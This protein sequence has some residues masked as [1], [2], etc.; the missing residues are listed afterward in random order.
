MYY[1]LITFASF[2]FALQF[3]FNNGY[4]K[5]NGSGWNSSLK[6]SFYTSAAGFF[7]VLII[8]NFQ[9]QIS[10]FSISVAIVYGIVNIAASY[11]AVKAFESANLSVYSVFSMIG[12]MLLPFLYGLI[13]G[14]PFKISRLICCIL[15]C[16]AV[17]F[18]VDKE[19]QN[20]NAFKYYIAVFVLN[21][22][23]GVISKFHQSYPAFCVDSGSFMILTNI[24]TFAL[25]LFLL[26]RLKDRTFSIS[27]KAFGLCGGFAAFTNVGNLLLLIALLHLPAT[28]QYPIV[29]GGVIVFSTLIDLVRRVPVSGRELMASFIAFAASVFM[30]F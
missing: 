14:E 20:W 10:L 3:L 21:G 28:V 2:L 1:F 18:T 29:T 9:L 6:F 13:C 30:A 11:S 7:F 16:F 12:G 19:R 15:I 27:G 24:T 25:S 8:N 23:A 5:K 4:Q 26:L 17:L 22:M